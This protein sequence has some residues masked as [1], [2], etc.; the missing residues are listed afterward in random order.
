MTEQEVLTLMKSSR[1]EYEWN[2]NCDAVKRAHNGG[3]PSFWYS[4]IIASGVL[5]WASTLPLIYT[6]EEMTGEA[7]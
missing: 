6:H 1:S 7:N 4:L 5:G 2:L 3:Y